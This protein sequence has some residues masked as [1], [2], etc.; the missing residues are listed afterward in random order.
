MQVKSEIIAIF[1][2]RGKLP[3]ILIEECQ[4]RGQKFQLFVL[5]NLDYDIDYSPFKP[6]KLEFGQVE[7]FINKIKEKEIKNLVFI[8]GV[9]R[10]NFKDLKLDKKASILLAKIA[11]KKI[12][13]DDSI[14][15]IIAKFFEKEGLNIVP[16]N[17]LLDGLVT[18]KGVLS[19]KLPDSDDLININLGKRAIKKL[20]KFDIGQS[21]IVCQ[22]QIVA[23][24]ALEGTDA[25]IKRC[26]KLNLQN[27]QGILVKMKKKFQSKKIDLPTIG[28]ETVKNC[29]KSGIK[30]IA[31]EANSVLLVEKEKL[32]KK[33]DELGLFL[34]VI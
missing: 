14:L 1:A 30:G 23:V 6:V 3:K 12:L 8:G 7:K 4:K 28:V 19:A 31:I 11:A 21:L 34:I 17:D 15:K 9:D 32:L 16:I 27:N 29:A 25:M 22:K 20:S 13:G 2:G 5:K 24:E 18:K 33:V 10:P 26:E